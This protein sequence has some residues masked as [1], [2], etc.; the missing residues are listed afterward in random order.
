MRP[1]QRRIGPLCLLSPGLPTAQASPRPVAATL[2]ITAP[3]PAV[4]IS[5]QVPP[6]RDGTASGRVTA[7]GVPAVEAGESRASTPPL[8]PPEHPIAAAP[9][10]PITASRPIALISGRI[11]Q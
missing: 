4:L 2:S 6:D 3:F 1:S 10:A 8:A 11:A 9:S 5:V 7:A